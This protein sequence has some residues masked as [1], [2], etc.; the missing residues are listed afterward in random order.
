MNDERNPSA[1]DLL[2]LVRSA[3]AA[4]DPV[5]ASVVTAA[6]VSLTWLTVD[7]ELASLIEDSAVAPLA[8]V[9]GRGPRLLTFEGADTTVV[10]EVTAVGAGRRLLGQLVDPR[11][12]DIEVRHVAGSLSVRADDLGRFT[13]DAVPAG[14]VSLACRFAGATCSVVTAWVT[15]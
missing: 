12:A 4:A 2:A 13:V 9:R 8:G 15:V 1:T 6:K 3:V 10:V 5:P 14:P 11:P 7:A